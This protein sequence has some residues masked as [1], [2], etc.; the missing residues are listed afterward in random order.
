MSRWWRLLTRHKTIDFVHSAPAIPRVVLSE[1]ERAA[2]RSRYAPGGKALLVFFGFLFEHKG[3]DDII[4]IMDPARHRLVV[5]GEVKEWD[6]YQVRLAERVRRE[7]ILSSVEMTGFLGPREAGSI[8]AAADAVVLPLRTGAG[9]WNTSLQ[10]AIL[11]G[12][13]ALTTSTERHGYDADRN[14]YFARPGDL[15]DLKNGLDRYLGRR[16]PREPGEE[17]LPTWA[18]IARKHMAIYERALGR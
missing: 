10:A 18:S 9:S 8:L 13:F 3:I 17:I 16:S 11:Q 5:V 12:T 4:A 7:P 14:A 6:P 2:L 15:A 1:G